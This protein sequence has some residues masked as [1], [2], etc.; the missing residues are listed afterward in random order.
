MSGPTSRSVRRTL[1]RLG[2]RERA[3]LLEYGFGSRWAL[4]RL[5]SEEDGAPLVDSVL[6]LHTR[7]GRRPPRPADEA[8]AAEAR[9]RIRRIQAETAKGGHL[10]K[11]HMGL[12]A[13]VGA[14]ALLW[15][16]PLVLV[17]SA[18][19]LV[20]VTPGWTQALFAA[21]LFVLTVFACGF[22]AG[23]G[24]PQAW[25]AVLPILLVVVGASAAASPLYLKHEGRDVQGEFVR[26]WTTGKGTRSE[27]RHC[28]LAWNDAGTR[29]L[30]K[31][32]GCPERFYAA[33]APRPGDHVAVPFVLSPGPPTSRVGTRADI[34]T[35]WQEYTAGTG[36]VLLTVLTAWGVTEAA[37]HRNRAGTRA[38]TRAR[39]RPTA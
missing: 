34:S 22:V 32:G 39:A 35:T 29:H 17:P 24:H 19:C 28:V 10:S 13:V 33:E 31:V 25:L 21:G 36:L 18:M 30:V 4:E 8:N 26:A 11:R 37:R 5:A 38:D 14:W 7:A 9:R 1:G 15:G 20:T 16:I 27:Q 23:R 3:R 6:A 2:E 12:R